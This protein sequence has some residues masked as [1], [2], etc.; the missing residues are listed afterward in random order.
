[1]QHQ[2][3]AMSV[4]VTLRAIAAWLESHPEI[5]PDYIDL[6]VID[7]LE[8]V[9]VKSFCH[10]SAYAAMQTMQSVG[11]LEP[12]ITTTGEDHELFRVSAEIGPN[13]RLDLLGPA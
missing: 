11:F 13:M 2:E 4:A 3:Q 1:M 7:G 12:E 6:P 5:R 9:V 10:P 8:L